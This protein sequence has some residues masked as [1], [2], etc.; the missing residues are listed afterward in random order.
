MTAPPRCAD[1]RSGSQEARAQAARP[2]RLLGHRRRRSGD[3]GHRPDPGLAK[4][5]EKAGWKVG[6]LDLVE[7]NEAFAAQACAVNKDMGWDPSIVNVN[8]GA[9]A[10]GHP[11][12]ASGARILNTLLHEMKRRGAKKGLATLCIGGG[13]GVACAW[14]ARFDRKLTRDASFEHGG[15]FPFHFSTV[16]EDNPWHE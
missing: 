16:W 15:A 1:D 6:D 3:H 4:A 5:L 12:G 14:N 2:H 8:G 11:I 9:I 13:M 10:I 7:A